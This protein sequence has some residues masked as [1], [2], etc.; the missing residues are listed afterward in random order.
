[1]AVAAFV[2]FSIFMYG[3]AMLKNAGVARWKQWRAAAPEAAPSM[4]EKV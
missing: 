1:M 3:L 4:V 2:G